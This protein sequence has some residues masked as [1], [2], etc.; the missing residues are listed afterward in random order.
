[1][2]LGISSERTPLGGFG[3]EDFRLEDFRQGD[4]LANGIN[5]EDAINRRPYGLNSTAPSRM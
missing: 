4:P 2:P 1:M 3:L 5:A